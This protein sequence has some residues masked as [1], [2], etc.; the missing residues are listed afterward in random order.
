[1][2]IWSKSI[3]KKFKKRK[4]S[5]WKINIKNIIKKIINLFFILNHST[6]N[7]L[8]EKAAEIGS[9]GWTTLEPVLI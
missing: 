6:K 5:S 1:M 8:L 3:F 2:K 7:R 4:I 9:P